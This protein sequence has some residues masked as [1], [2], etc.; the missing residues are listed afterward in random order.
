VKFIRESKPP[1]KGAA[2]F[3]PPKL[4]GKRRSSSGAGASRLQDDL[5]ERI[6]IAYH[7]LTRTRIRNVRGRVAGVLNTTQA[8]GTDTRWGSA[9]VI[10]RVRQFEERMM[11]EHGLA[12]REDR[13]KEIKRLKS[14]LRLFPEGDRRCSCRKRAMADRW[15]EDHRFSTSESR[16]RDRE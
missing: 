6:Y 16:G 15:I 5:T 14:R 9:E 11:R 1:Y 13:A 8:R 3:R 10:E 12:G 7:A 2:Q 4:L